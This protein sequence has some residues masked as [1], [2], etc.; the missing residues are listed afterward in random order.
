MKKLVIGEDSG[1]LFMKIENRMLSNP[2]PAE[3]G[4]ADDPG[5]KLRP[6]MNDGIPKHLSRHRCLKIGKFE[7]QHQQGH[8]DGKHPVADGGNATVVEPL[9]IHDTSLFHWT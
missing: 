8:G 7:V 3:N 5:G 6:L 4:E 2:E 1:L 9:M